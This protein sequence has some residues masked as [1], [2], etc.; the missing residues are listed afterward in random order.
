MLVFYILSKIVFGAKWRKYHIPP[1]FKK[2]KEIGLV[3]KWTGDSP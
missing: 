3:E 1:S 2:K